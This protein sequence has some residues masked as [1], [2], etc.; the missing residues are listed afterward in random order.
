MCR[1]FDGGKIAGRFHCPRG[2]GV[3]RYNN[4]YLADFINNR[5]RK[6]TPDRRVTTL[7]GDGTF[8]HAV[9]RTGTS[10]TAGPAYVA[11][12]T[13]GSIYFTDMVRKCVCICVRVCM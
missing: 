1:Y 9:G 12:D 10:K 7:V 6:I 3:D 2:I 4:L 5:I 8:R 13:W 11:V